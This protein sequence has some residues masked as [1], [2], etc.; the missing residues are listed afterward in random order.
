MFIGH[1]AALAAAMAWTTASALW[2][3]LSQFGTAIELNGLKNGLAL[4][5]FLPFLFTLPWTDQIG[6]IVVLLLSGVIGIAAGDSFYL[7]GLRRL[8]TQRAL[9][10]EAI[11]PVLASMGGVLMMGDT[12]RPASWAGALLVSCA[13]VLVAQQSKASSATNGTAFGLLLCVLAV[14]C[15]LSGAFLSRHVLITSSLSPMQTAAIRL[16]GG[17]LGLLPLLRGRLCPKHL[18]KGVVAKVVLATLLGTNLG[19][20]LQQIVFQILPVGQGITLMSTAPVMAL[21]LHRLEGESLQW[22]GVVAG[23]LAVSGVGLSSL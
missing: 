12:V 4:L 3:S 20:V 7:G 15:G 14:M 5:F 23:L 18:P 10:V 6:A 19:I 21:F 17:W 1:Q 22:Q 13:V 11:G 8:G 16:L 9:T 2:R